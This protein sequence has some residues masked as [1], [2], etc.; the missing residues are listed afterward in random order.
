MGGRKVQGALKS[1]ES[2]GNCK[3]AIRKLGWLLPCDLGWSQGLSWQRELKVPL[4]HAGAAG[5]P[6]GLQGWQS[7]SQGLW[8]S[9]QLT[10]LGVCHEDVGPVGFFCFLRQKDEFCQGQILITGQ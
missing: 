5:V 6:A 1:K 10:K 7:G 9:F 4:S 3:A 8:L 2:K